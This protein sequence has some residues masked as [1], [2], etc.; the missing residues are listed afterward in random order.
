MLAALGL[1]IGNYLWGDLLMLQADGIVLRDRTTVG[2]TSVVRIE[3]VHVRSGQTVSAGDTLLRVGS[4]EI[5][6]R[7]A[8]LSSR[9]ADLAQRE[10]ALRSRRRLADDLLP[11][12]E[13]RADEAAR[14]LDRLDV[15]LDRGLVVTE[16]HEDAMRAH[17]DAQ[18][19]RLRLASER[20]TLDAEI[21]ALATARRTVTDALRELKAHF[22]DGAIRATVSGTVGVDVPAVG[23]VY[24]AGEPLLSVFSGDTYVLAYLPRSYVFAIE[25]GMT[26]RV[27]DGRNSAEGA[28]AG[29]LPVSQA[30]PEEL[31]TAFQPGDRRQLARIRISGEAQFP[32]FAGVHVTRPL[33]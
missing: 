5:L 4:T 10:A 22:R 12:A 17:F 9:D 28:I 33:F 20:R 3:A 6:D 8:D 13:R 27:T 14:V 25:P 2:A 1:G 15:A 21:A 7:I 18:T 19:A 31:R 30:L 16:R 24:S 32:V 11:F 29:I 26:V 23:E